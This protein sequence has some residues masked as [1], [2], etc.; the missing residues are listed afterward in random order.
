M[1][2]SLVITS[3]QG[4][5][6]VRFFSAAVIKDLATHGGSD[7]GVKILKDTGLSS[8]FDP[9]TTLR[10]FF[11]T[12]YAAL[13]RSYRSE[14]IYKN[15]IAQKVL[16]GTHSLKTSFMLTEFRSALCRADVVLL[17]GTS[18]VYEIKSAYDSMGRLSRQIQAYRQLFDK[19]CVITAP[20][21]VE[22]VKQHIADDIGLLVLSDRNTL[23]TIQEP[24]SLKSNVLPT[25]IF[26]SLRQKEYEEIVK[27]HF[28]S[29]PNVPNTKIY[30]ACHDL[31][32]TLDPIDAHDSMVSILKKRG[33]N[34]RLS[35]FIESVPAS[36]KAASLS[37]N[38]NAK[39]QSQFSLLLNA[40]IGDCL[41]IC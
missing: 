2:K 28:G 20:S 4:P 10:S 30:Q 13:F 19:V 32:C 16:L 6:L 21:Q 25:T 18:T 9:A 1:K 14:Y 33:G 39:E 35:E 34:K 38:L 41:S 5:A 3:N 31:F 11:D 40:E 27:A 22:N 23:R 12:I 8:V 37:C 15:V 26:D 7:L 36:L 17:N 24:S 29:V